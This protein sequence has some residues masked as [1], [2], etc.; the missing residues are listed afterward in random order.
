M[1]SDTATT[2]TATIRPLAEVGK[3]LAQKRGE[4]ETFVTAHTKTGADGKPQYSMNTSELEEMNRRIAE[5]APLEDERTRAAHIEGAAEQNTRLLQE[6]RMTPANPLAFGA[7][8]GRAD[9]ASAAAMQSAMA[10]MVGGASLRTAAD[11]FLDSVAFKEWESKGKPS[12]KGGSYV[13]TS[14]TKD[15]GYDEIMAAHEFRATMSTGAGWLPFAPRLPRVVM[16]PQLEPMLADLIPQ[17][18]VE[19]PA[20]SYMEETTATNAADVV[21]EGAPKPEAT[22]ILTPQ[23]FTMSKIAVTLPVTD[24]QLEDVSQLRAYIEQRLAMF[25]RQKEDYYLLNANNAGSGD[26]FY[27]FLNKAGVQTQARGTDPIP[28]AYLK[29]MTKIRYG[30]SINVMNAEPSGIVVHPNDYQD[31]IT[32]Q[33]STGQYLFGTPFM[34]APLDDPARRIWGK[35]VIITPQITEN[36]SLIGDFARFSSIFRRKQLTM[37]MGWANDDYLKNIT[38][39]RCEQRATLIIWRGSAFCKVTGV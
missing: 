19:A 23:T 1:S 2:A 31:Y 17:S 35:Q 21:A 32:Y 7:M 3:E 27:G 30:A 26:N 13:I 9:T 10:A 16:L 38:R 11:H 34:G 37:D 12:F 6:L 8:S 25:V 14:E 22:L 39:F 20:G 29:A 24:E 18:N 36:T 5:I 4:L 33:T 28:T 15:Y